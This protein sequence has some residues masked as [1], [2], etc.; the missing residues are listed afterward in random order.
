M[1]SLSAGL[2]AAL[3]SSLAGSA[4]ADA[5]PIA[6]FFRI[7]Q[8]ADMRIS[9]DGKHIA[10][11]APVVGR[12]NLVLLDLAGRKG[13]PITSSEAVD[14]VWFT[15]L[16]DKRVLLL[17]G[18]LVER[19]DDIR[20][21]SE[22]IALDLDGSSPYR[23]SRPRDPGSRRDIMGDSVAFGSVRPLVLVR[24]LPDSDEIVMQ[25]ITFDRDGRRG[26]GSLLRL[27]TRGGAQVELGVGKPDSGES[28]K[29]VVD[30]KG[31]ARGF[32]AYR[33]GEAA[34]YYRG[35]ADAP[36][37]KV[38]EHPQSKPGTTLLAVDE[39][40][41]GLFVSAYGER[42]KGA[43]Y[44]WSGATS[45]RE[46]QVAAHPQVDLSHL[47]YDQGNVVGVSYEADARGVAYFDE[48]IAR[49]QKAIDAA[50]PGMVNELQ[51]SRD[52][53]KFVVTSSSGTSPGGFYLFDL[54]TGKL[55]WL[56]D[57]R[58]WLK[59]A[60]LATRQA[61]R[62]KARDGLEIPAYLTVPRGSEG[63]RLPMVVV[64]HGGP[65]MR[66]ATGSFDSEAQFLASRGYAVLEPNFRGTTGYGWK[67]F[68]ASFKQ[69]GLAMQDDIT[70]GVQWAVDQGIADAK[71]VCI[72][73]ASYGGYAAMMGL[74]KTPDVFRCAINMV[75]VTDIR[76][77]LTATWTDFAYSDYVGYL[78]K[79]I[80]GDPDKDRALLDANS[81]ARLAGKM[82][83]AVLMAYG[84]A[85]YRVPLVHGNL[86]KDA[87]DKASV[88]YEWMVMEGEG[89]GFYRLEN[90][91]AF[92]SA[93]ERFLAE[94]L[95]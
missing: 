87:L 39:D 23:V 49:V 33:R 34:S 60:S 91:V 57:R 21:R 4:A 12:Q 20:R 3:A 92:Y 78:S 88:K 35:S 66:G 42:D 75:G 36:W 77:M 2:V 26:A 76:T 52:R 7:P 13:Q 81:P 17:T 9:P 58:P 89:H 22:Y 19:D 8:Y 46:G 64:A 65:W 53:T 54:K 28:E 93:V 32:S 82:K 67:H 18:S 86:M 25:E 70:D 50:L 63:K 47:V 51:W 6:D 31:V 38:D 73:G 71:R 62:Y 43:I 74:A 16:T 72:Y 85:D 84:A 15:W 69:W 11:L 5:V 55:E 41:P 24:T 10:A 40:E 61:V 83:G 1:R 45:K 90:R 37:V 94:H 79:D 44:K 56:A 30:N 48:A 14:V 80:V 95:K 29:W 27:N 59:P 68:S